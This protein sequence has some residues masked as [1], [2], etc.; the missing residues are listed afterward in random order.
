M[1]L[2]S[3]PTLLYYQLIFIGLRR[4]LFS[5]VSSFMISS[6]LCPCMCI[7]PNWD[8]D[9]A[10]ILSSHVRRYRLTTA[11]RLSAYLLHYSL[12]MIPRSFP[13]TH[14]CRRYPSTF[15]WLFYIIHRRVQSYYP[16]H[17]F[18]SWYPTSCGDHVVLTAHDQPPKVPFERIETDT[19][20]PQ[21]IIKLPDH[22]NFD[23]ADDDYLSYNNVRPA[24]SSP[25][26]EKL[27]EHLR[28]KRY[29]EEHVRA[30][31]VCCRPLV[32]VVPRNCLAIFFHNHSRI[33]QTH[34]SRP[35]SQRILTRWT[36]W[37]TMNSSTM[38]I[39]SAIRSCQAESTLKQKKNR[40]Y[41]P[42]CWISW[43]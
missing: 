8:S 20:I 10:T 43:E 21:V 26:L 12:S 42:S 33:L 13:M 3:F 28:R 11:I 16:H 36:A 38:P 23:Q 18:P 6:I 15:I 34:I 17:F 32:Y 37:R 25:R 4:P 29:I 24:V 27:Q 39:S 2:L 40:W 31:P 35:S 5:G 19:D 22:S 41:L 1:L 7:V 30:V 14:Q 9:C